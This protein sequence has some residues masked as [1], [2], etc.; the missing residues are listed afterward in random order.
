MQEPEFLKAEEEAQIDARQFE[1]LERDMEQLTAEV[2][3]ETPEFDDSFFDQ[4]TNLNFNKEAGSKT[5]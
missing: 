1:K 3:D 2:D 5:H 4:E